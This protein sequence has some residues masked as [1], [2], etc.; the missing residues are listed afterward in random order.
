MYSQYDA[1]PLENI[2]REFLSSESALNLGEKQPG[3]FFSSSLVVLMILTIDKGR[4][5]RKLLE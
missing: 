4:T 3:I 1:M 2:D 5:G